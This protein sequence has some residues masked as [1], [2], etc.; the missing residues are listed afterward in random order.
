MVLKAIILAAGKGTRL[1]PLTNHTPKALI[2]VNG[3]SLI[4]RHLYA[5]KSAGYQEIVINLCYLGELIEQKLKNG[6]QYGLKISY[7][8][9]YGKELETAGGIKQALPLLGNQPFLVIN[10]DI[11]TDFPFDKL[12]KNVGEAHLILT[13]NPRNYSGDFN[14]RAGLLTNEK[15]APYT[16]CGIGVYNPAFFSKIPDGK[17]ALGKILREKVDKKLVTGQ[18]YT[19]VWHDVGTTERLEAV[20][21]LRY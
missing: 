19:G 16:Y 18:L 1:K 7:S 5:L 14:L 13:P 3:E 4:E 20:T 8:K 11:L 6:A 15:H 10:A 2:S 12:P 21:Q 17:I 9:E